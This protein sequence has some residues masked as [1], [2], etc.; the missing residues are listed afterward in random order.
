M[1]YLRR[2]IRNRFIDDLRRIQ[3]GP[4]EIV[5][6]ADL[7]EN[8]DG[9]DLESMAISADLVE[10]MFSL[11]SPDEREIL[12]FWAVEGYSSRQLARHLD[13]PH[14]TVLSR[15][16]RMRKK[17]IKSFGGDYSDGLSEVIV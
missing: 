5:S 17:L 10:Q 8:H 14:G 9:R 16:Y 6:M 4:A 3:N 11:L 1:A 13:I 2:I 12:Y 7:P 15:I